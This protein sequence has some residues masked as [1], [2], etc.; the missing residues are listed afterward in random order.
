MSRLRLSLLALAVGICLAHAIPGRAGSPALPRQTSLRRSYALPLSFEA[1]Q[2][3]MDSAVKYVAR[4]D[5]YTLFLTSDA[6]VLGLRGAGTTLGNGTEWLRMR[7]QGAA[8]DAVVGGDAPVGATSNYFVGNDRSKWRTNIPNFSRVRYQQVYPGVDV[9][10]Y[11][12][13]GR[14]EN[15]FEVSPGTNPNVIAWELD[16]AQNVRIDSTGDLILT[17]GGNKVRLHQPIAY[18]ADGT[19]RRE[20]PVRYHLNGQKVSF[21][22][23]NYD[24]R[25]KLV[26]DPLLTYSTYLGGSG[27]DSAYSVAVDASNDVFVTGIT[28]STNFPFSASEFQTVNAGDGDVFITQFNPAGNGIIFS[29][30]LGGTGT[31]TPAQILLSLGSIFLVGSTTSN[32]FPTTANVFQPDYSGNQD[33]FLTEMKLDGTALIYSTYIGGTGADFGTAVA[34]DSSG[35]AYV[36]GSTQ[37]T[38]FPTKNPI[39]LGNVGQADA[40]VTEVGSQGTLMYSTYLGGTQ[41][42][43][44]TGIAVTTAGDVIISGYTYSS[45]YPTQNALQSTLSGGSDLFVTK[46]TPGSATLLFSTYLG[47]SSIDRSWAMAVDSGENIYLT[48]DT[49]SPDFP[50]TPNSYQS[51]LGGTDNVFLVKLTQGASA[52]TFSTF[53]G[54]AASDQASAITLDATNNIYLTGFTESGNFPLIDPFQHSLGLSG[55][56]N[57]GSSNLLNVPTL[58]CS[59]AFV[60]KFAP[61]GLP[62]FSS[63]LGGLGNDAGQGIAVD[64]TGSIYVVGGTASPNFPATSNAYQWLYQGVNS[65]TNAFLTKISQTD[66]PSVALSPQQVNFGSEPLQSSASPVTIT[67]ANMGSGSLN[68]TSISAVGDF[69]QTNNCGSF[70]SGGGGT[71]TIQVIFTP[72]AV[73]LQTSQITIDD[74]AGTGIQTITVTGNGVLSGGSLIF[75]PTKLTF[76][77]QTVGTTSPNQSALL[78]N[79]GNKAVTITDISVISDVFSQTNNCGI[80]FP[81]VPA[82]LNVGQSCT[83]S[84]N[85]TPNASGTLAANINVASNALTSNV[86]LALTGTGTSVFSLSAN[87]RSSVVTVGTTAAQFTVSA[88]GPSSIRQDSITLKCSSGVTCTFNPAQI[89]PGASSLV[90]VTGLSP[91]SA[92]PFNFTVTGSSNAQNSSVALSIF[93]ADF[94]LS[95]TPSGTTV[96]AGNV[97]TYTISVTPTSGFNEPVL[98]NCPAASAIPLGTECFFNPP[99]VV[100]TGVVGSSV[101]STL[102]ISTDAQSRVIPRPPPSG[103]PP[104]LGR[105]ILLMALL[106]FLGVIT[107]GFSRSKLWLRPQLRIGVLFAGIV[108]AALAVGCENYVNP[109]NINPVV[110]GTPS[111]NYYIVLTGTLGNG[112]GVTRG[113]TIS[114]S[115]LP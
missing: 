71:C 7:L 115:V 2:G 89:S 38:D 69:T 25:Q 104:G 40:F 39:Q 74:N 56:G 18:Q 63:F 33:A 68:I 22:L 5:G 50:V 81:T 113:T 103:M 8:A 95:A 97:A 21:S 45:N 51:T 91:T 111:G 66:G 48:G 57:C 55:A 53:F 64:T 13:E 24:R 6:T 44:A 15:D 59:D 100:P 72:S 52:V 109:I 87:S 31:D 32:N 3:Q 58:L 54:G 112:S 102:T 42:D 65:G 43:Y 60:A 108:L 27:G 11:G 94:S 16:G 14:L 61:S 105:W 84:A 49:Q 88:S 101:T 9:V 26:I 17:V 114:L 29:T 70:V 82:T 62:V 76:A 73:G 28:A 34:V 30:F 75:T 92:N 36:T 46:F 77:A 85:F 23:G 78:I 4:G 79:N 10:Y 86:G 35:N 93:F 96:T 19:Q 110:N 1:N 47:G 37:S 20:V 41:N 12:H 90:T 98:L 99:T 83:I 106:L 107:A 67:L 80:N